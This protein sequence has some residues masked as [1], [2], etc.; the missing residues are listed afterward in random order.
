MRFVRSTEID[1]H[2]DLATV[3]ITLSERMEV[4]SNALL[5]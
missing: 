5:N 4:L 2:G 3:V 1:E